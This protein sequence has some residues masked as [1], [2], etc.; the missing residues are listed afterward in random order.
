MIQIFKTLG[1]SIREHKKASIQTP[2][3]VACEV[4]METVIPLVMASLIDEMTGN[5]MP[6]ILKYGAILL[7]LAMTSLFF[8]RASAIKAATA[9]TGFSKNLRNDMYAR[10][11]DFAFA[12]VD[13]FSTSS[14]ITR[15]T[16]DVNNVQNAYGM[17]IRIAVRTPLM[18][19]FSI[20]MAFTINAKMAWIFIGIIPIV[21]L[22]LFLI[23]YKVMPLFRRIFKKY[24]IF[25]ESVE[26]NISGIRVVKSF[27]RE[28]YEQDKFNETAENLEKDF[29]HAEKI[30]ALN[31]PVMMAATFTAMLLLCILGAQL[32]VNTGATQLT[33]GQLSSLMSY[34]MQILMSLMMLSMVIIM[35]ILSEESARRIAEVLEYKSTLISPENGL[36]KV[37]DGSIDFNQVSFK[38]NSQSKRDALSDVNLY[39][40][41]GSKIGRAHV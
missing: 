38:Y 35:I 9:S 26:E 33:T 28:D 17:I 19:I 10:I 4:V 13:K 30:M 21:I 22:A 39:I 25:N 27:V 3:V 6:P 1:T 8:G 32:I 36:M 29:V 34:G 41:S 18:M 11:Q 12:D 24:D 31:N 20:I 2:V 14:L 40:P 23:N 7:V 15:M 37:E 16:T 5:S